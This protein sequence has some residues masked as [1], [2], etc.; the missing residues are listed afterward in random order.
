MSTGDVR[1]FGLVTPTHVLEDICMDVPH[2][3]EVVIPADKANRSRDLYRAISQKCV[4]KLPDLPPPAHVAPVTYLRDDVLQERN[5]HLE[6]RNK[7]LEEENAQL[8]EALKEALSQ[9]TQLD[10]ILA[11]VHNVKIP[12]VMVA[13]QAAAPRT[14]VADGTAPQFIPE[15]IAPKDAAVRIDRV[16]QE[17]DSAGIS[18]AAAKLRKMRKGG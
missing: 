5:H 4:F 18:D 17:A 13:G 3:R 1:V 8:R 15:E 11:A 6:T 7:H 12:T 14:D 2:G 16:A 10:A 9:R